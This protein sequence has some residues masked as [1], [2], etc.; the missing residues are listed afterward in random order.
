MDNVDEDD[1]MYEDEGDG[2]DSDDGFYSLNESDSEDDQRTD[3]TIIFRPLKGR[4]EPVFCV[5]MIFRIRAELAGA[6]RQHSMLQGKEIRFLKNETT[7]VGAK[8]KVYNPEEGKKD[9]TW[10][11]S[12]TNTGTSSKTLQVKVYNPNHNCGR[13]WNNKL[14]NSNWLVRIYFNDIKI[15]PSLKTS[16]LTEKVR[17]NFKCNVSLTQ[18]YKAKCKVLRKI[19]GQYANL[20]DYCIEIKKEP[21]RVLVCIYI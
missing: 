3:K 15:S 6:I 12:A 1:R 2:S 18:C 11:I 4:E 17:E 5:G 19:E 21:I 7:K 8:C 9:C 14:M 10:E 20:W 13:I 16:E